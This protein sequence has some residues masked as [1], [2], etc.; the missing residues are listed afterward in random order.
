MPISNLRRR[1]L[2][3]LLALAAGMPL[4]AAAADL[5][6]LLTG[7]TAPA[8][9]VHMPAFSLATAAGGTLKSDDLK[10]KVVVARFWATW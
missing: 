10:G 5:P 2:P 9:P 4:A 1:I 8:K 3:G 7:L 6:P